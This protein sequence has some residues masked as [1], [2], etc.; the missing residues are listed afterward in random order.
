MALFV[1]GILGVNEAFFSF[2]W[3]VDWIMDLLGSEKLTYAS[4]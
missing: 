1:M 2:L 3:F 4:L